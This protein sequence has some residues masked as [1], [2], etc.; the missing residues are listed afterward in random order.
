MGFWGP[1]KAT[2]VSVVLALTG[3]DVIIPDDA[4]SPFPQTRPTGLNPPVPA[5]PPARVQ[6][7]SA[8]SLELATYY[9]RLENDLLV[10]GLLRQDGGGIDVPYNARNLAENFTQIALFDEY[11][12]QTGGFVA[13]PTASRLRKWDKPIRMSVEFG[14]SIN[15]PQRN[16]DRANIEKY[17]QRLSR[18]TQIPITRTHNNPN[19]IVMVLNEDDR[20]GFV[21]RVRSLVPGIS[22]SALRTFANMPRSTL[23]LV[24][25]F[26][27][28]AA[29]SSYSKA[30]AVVR[31]EHPDLLR[32]SCIHE[33]L[34][35]GMGLAND[36]P[37][38]R[39][40]IF[41]DDEEFGLLTTHDEQL[42]R[43]LYDP[44]LK[45]G[46]AEQEA[47]PIINQIAQELT[48][49]VI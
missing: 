40:S 29:S 25:A 21:P 24:L 48:G 31:G 36:S 33:E 20:L 45:S 10:Q 6:P 8:A 19:F 22:D 38:A 15:L 4:A 49:S 3:C 14:P 30:I 44:R 5:A 32:L 13:A 35:Q 11:N 39:P 46:M 37:A 17:S 9:K 16:T 7:Q 41:N 18:L 26:S 28:D 23:C 2:C 27:A 42:L 34:A 47:R 12:S 1:L 43:M